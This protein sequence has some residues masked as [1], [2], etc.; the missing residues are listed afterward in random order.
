MGRDLVSAGR[1]FTG[2]CPKQ[3]V[4]STDPKSPRTRQLKSHPCYTPQSMEEKRS[5]IPELDGIRGIAILLVLMVH[6]AWNRQL[7]RNVSLV[8]YFGWIGVDLFFVLSGFLIT[9]ILLST[10]GQENFFFNFYWNRTMRIFP[11]YYLCLILSAVFQ[12]EAKQI[13]YWLFLG[14]L[15]N[16]TGNATLSLNHFWSLAIEEQFYWIWP[17]VV[18]YLPSRRI[19]TICAFL[20]S[21]TLVARFFVAPMHLPNRYFVYSLTPLRWDA[22][23]FGALIASLNYHRKLAALEWTLK[24]AALAGV[25]LITTTIWYTRGTECTNSTFERYGYLGVDVFFAS[26]VAGCVLRSGSSGFALARTPFLRFF[27][28][29]SYA[30]YVV[31]FPISLALR[32]WA[33][34][35]MHPGA[36]SA[37][38]FFIGT[39]LSVSIALLSWN[40]IEKHFLS[41][42]RENS[43]R[44]QLAIA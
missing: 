22:L 28:K 26:L 44:T 1:A 30:I 40:L 21:L 9:R 36:A 13:L 33:A 34:E 11:L 12:P 4:G 15:L 5:R 38:C 41:Y 10:R 6:F 27:G 2:L 16:A 3:D 32:A 29:Y 8:F 19:T 42:R 37:F 20:I 25:I 14:N 31:H 24:W 35:H 7:P 39:L 17:V 23:L 43:A 18:C